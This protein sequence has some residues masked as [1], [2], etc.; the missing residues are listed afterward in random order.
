MKREN[1][2]MENERDMPDWQIDLRSDR[3]QIAERILPIA[4]GA[5]ALFSLLYL[6]IYFGLDRPWQWAWMTFLAVLTTAC[7]IGAYV[8]VRRGRLSTVV[9]LMASGI[10][11]HVIASPALIEGLVIEGILV[12]LLV[13][14]FARLLAGRIENRVVVFISGIALLTGVLLSIFPVWDLVP[15]PAWLQAVI[16]GITTTGV[17][18]LTGLILEL[19]DERYEKSLSQA[20]EYAVELDARRKMFEERTLALER[21][22]GYLEATN[23]VSR[24]AASILDLQELLTRAVEAIGEKFDFYRTAIFLVDTTGE[25]VEVQSAFGVGVQSSLARGFR[26]RVG[27]EG[28]VGRVAEMG[29]HY[30]VQDTRDDPYFLRDSEVT[31]PL[32]EAALPLRARDELIGVLDVQSDKVNAFKNEDV[33]V[34]Q[35][36]ADQI[37][38]AIS[39]ARL[40][41]Q[42]EE[43]LKVA[44]RAYGELS[45]EAWEEMLSGGLDLGYYCDADGVMPVTAPMDESDDDLPE[46][47]IPV[48]VRGQVIGAIAAHKD[49]DAGEWVSEE[50]A[51]VKTLSERLG[52]ALESA[53]LYKDTQR[54][55]AREQI[56]GQVTTR[57]RETLDMDTVLKTAVQEV[58]QA[59]GLPEVVIRLAPRPANEAQEGVEK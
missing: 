23:V 49:A 19:R 57:M 1:N 43:N 29:K 8:L 37:A 35:T 5:G 39:N 26:L 48:V 6:L 41:Q 56:I 53:R 50:V 20:E 46:L 17:I 21:R 15:T 2:I 34:L 3:V 47:S 4:V 10:I 28:I 51:L 11:L 30:V 25:W 33:S 40:F 14:M 24:D 18:F 22:T 7:Y 31:D 13:I 52:G 42:A 16:A 38:L 54:H 59:L 58:R 9:Y 55:A 12:S 32:S 36:L 45:R 44:Q 27:E